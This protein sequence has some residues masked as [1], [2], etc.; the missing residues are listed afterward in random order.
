[1]KIAFIGLGV[2][3]AHM[4]RHLA[5]AG[6]HMWVYN[7]TREKAAAWVQR[8][9]GVAYT[10]PAEACTGADIAITCVGDDP[11]VDEVMLGKGGILET[12]AAGT[13]IVDH[14]TTSAHIARLIHGHALEKDVGF[15]DAPVSGGESGAESGQLTIMCGGEETHFQTVEPVLAT[16]AKS[17][18]LLGPSG[19]GQLTKMVNQ[20][21][22]AGLI[23]S[24]A[25]ALNFGQKAG[26]DMDAIIDVI[27]KG[28]A[29]S[30]QMDNRAKTMIK[31]EFD[32]GFAVDW[33]RKDLRICL[34]QAEDLNVPLPVAQVVDGFYADVQDAGGSR[35]DTSSLMVRLTQ[36]Q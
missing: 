25:E 15:V 32:F 33:M 34:A 21:C 27:S 6:Q 13:V 20:I 18:R 24:L 5:A 30:W 22:L 4:A 31:G 23:Q 3:G 28:A 11:D 14:T 29:Q 10:S 8:H 1:M 35:W 36:E 19:S 2:M 7:R 17:V 9:G 16:Y 12:M 26:L